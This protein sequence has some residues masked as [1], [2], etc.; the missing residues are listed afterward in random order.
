MRVCLSLPIP[1]RCQIHWRLASLTE[2]KPLLVLWL[3]GKYW[4]LCT[5]SN[6]NVLSNFESFVSQLSL[7]VDALFYHTLT[8]LDLKWYVINSSNN[9]RPVM[10]SI[11][12]LS[13][14]GMTEWSK[15]Y[16]S[17][18]FVNLLLFSC[19]MHLHVSLHNDFMAFCLRARCIAIDFTCWQYVESF[20]LIQG[21]VLFGHK[22]PVLNLQVLWLPSCI[23]WYVPMHEMAS[24]PAQDA[25]LL[26][27][28]ISVYEFLTNICVWLPDSISA[29][30]SGF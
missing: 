13:C 5:W 11:C 7:R 1:M 15:L 26:F 24:P 4:S 20:L 18:R 28:S 17:K 21:R 2:W 3:N 22:L 12:P 19:L 29:R 8:F 6:T 9:F 25:T 14:S 30:H 16:V 23:C 27:W 10:T